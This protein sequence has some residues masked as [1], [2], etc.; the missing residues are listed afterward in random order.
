MIKVYRKLTKDQKSRGV[1]FSSTLSPRPTD[2]IE[3]LTTH[4]V[5]STN[6]DREEIINRLL[7]DSFFD[8]SMFKYNII[9]KA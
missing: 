8:G 6:K 7:D 2:D 1:V 5:L 4:E 3:G 9:R